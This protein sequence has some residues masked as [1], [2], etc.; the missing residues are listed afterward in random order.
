MEPQVSYIRLLIGDNSRTAP[1]YT[2]AQLRAAATVGPVR[3]SLPINVRL[4]G[5]IGFRKFPFANTPAGDVLALSTLTDE[6]L[7]VLTDEQLSTLID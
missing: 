3:P 1:L 4:A 7:A 6:Q 5:N 2:D